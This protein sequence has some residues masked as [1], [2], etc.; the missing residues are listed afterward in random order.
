[1]GKRAENP[2]SDSFISNIEGQ[3]CAEITLLS[4]I[5][6]VDD[7]ILFC[8]EITELFHTSGFRC[9]WAS[10]AA[11]AIS[12]IDRNRRIETVIL[13]LCL[14]GMAGMEAAKLLLKVFSRHRNFKLFIVSGTG[15]MNDVISALRLGI[16]DY[17]VKPLDPQQF[18]ATVKASIYERRRDYYNVSYNILI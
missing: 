15:S 9:H 8:K 10:A 4:E 11:E 18:L 12:M 3:S 1:M 16:A 17:F 14:P 2:A 5:L 13:D 7:D 6:I